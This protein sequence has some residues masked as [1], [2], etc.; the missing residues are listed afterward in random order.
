[1]R[2]PPAVRQELLTEGRPDADLARVDRPRRHVAAQVFQMENTRSLNCCSS[3]ASS[4]KAC[5]R[6]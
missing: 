2:R 3:S 6:A 5:G 4:A 1:M